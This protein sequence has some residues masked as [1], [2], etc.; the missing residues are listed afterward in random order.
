MKNMACPG[1]GPTRREPRWRFWESLLVF[2]TPAD[3]TKYYPIAT[4]TSRWQ[5]IRRDTAMDQEEATQSTALPRH[6]RPEAR[7]RIEIIEN[8]QQC[9][10]A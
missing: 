1:G 9:V 4:G 10:F 7:W 3:T 8:H 5:Q 6:S 2:K